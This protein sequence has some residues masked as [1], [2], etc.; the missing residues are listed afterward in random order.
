MQ[1]IYGWRDGWNNGLVA[2]LM[3]WLMDGYMTWVTYYITEHDIELLTI[4]EITW[5][6]DIDHD[7]VNYIHSDSTIY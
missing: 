7:I 4:T 3:D 6:T 1:W 2:E 5:L